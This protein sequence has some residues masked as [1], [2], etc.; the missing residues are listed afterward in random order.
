MSGRAT[1][2]Q[3]DADPYHDTKPYH[4]ASC[5]DGKGGVSALCFPKPKAI[6]LKV[7]SWTIREKAVTC[8]K[9]R[10]LL[11]LVEQGGVLQ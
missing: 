9:C 11:K 2:A 8:N 5:V 3:F 7:A 4:Y 10:S 6:N 1:S